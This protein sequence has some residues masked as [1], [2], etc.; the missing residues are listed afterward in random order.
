LSRERPFPFTH[1]DGNAFCP[2]RTLELE[3]A[4]PCFRALSC[5]ENLSPFAS[6][7]PPQTLRA[8]LQ[9]AGLRQPVG[10]RCPFPLYRPPGK[11]K[12]E[13]LGFCTVP[14]TRFNCMSSDG[15]CGDT[16]K[17]RAFHRRFSQEGLLREAAWLHKSRQSE[18]RSKARHESCKKTR[19]FPQIR[20]E[21]CHQIPRLRS[22]TKRKKRVLRDELEG[23]VR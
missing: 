5:L 2:S 4:R 1:L 6:H 22:M 18:G 7:L 13:T 21:C 14:E 3:S 23:R 16:S 19:E 20:W 9:N 10:G 8:P 15:C 12:R 11:R 17:R